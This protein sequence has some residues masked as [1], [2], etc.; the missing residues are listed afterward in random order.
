MALRN[1][2]SQ[3]CI[4]H[5]S[6]GSPFFIPI[7]IGSGGNAGSQA[8]TLIVRAIS[9]NDLRITQYLKAF[10]KE[11]FVG[12]MLGA[13]MGLSSSVLG[14]FKADPTVAVVVGVTMFLIIFVA[15]LIGTTIPFLLT[16]LKV[17]PAV[18][19]SPLITTIADAVG[20]LIYFFV[21]TQILSISNV[22]HSG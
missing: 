2:Q 17:D 21:A 11:I 4:P 22:P 1:P 13:A 18:A 20:L 16:K 6:S 19:S 10:V 14:F 9:T 3:A 15:N 12:A 5:I 8:V 7:L